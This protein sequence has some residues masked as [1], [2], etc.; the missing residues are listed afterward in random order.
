M[1]FPKIKKV[2]RLRCVEGMYA[3]GLPAEVR[4]TTDGPQV[5]QNIARLGKRDFYRLGVCEVADI[6]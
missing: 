4:A 1:R 3:S 6:V 5:A 2:N